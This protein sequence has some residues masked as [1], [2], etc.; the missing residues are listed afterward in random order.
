MKEI[1]VLESM[2]YLPHP[3]VIVTAGNPTDPK[4]R[5]GMTAAWV[6]R[7]SW[8]PPLIAVAIAPSRHTY[9]LIKEFKEFAVHTISKNLEEIAMRIFGSMSSRDVDKFKEAGIEPAKAKAITAPIIPNAPLIL[10]CKLVAEHPAGD[11]IIVIGEVVKAYQGSNENPL[12]WWKNKI[13]EV[14]E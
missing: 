7:V 11:H 10:E 14:K 9:K 6:S 12:V 3:L 8:N 4:N 2:E 1:G 5:G 13:A